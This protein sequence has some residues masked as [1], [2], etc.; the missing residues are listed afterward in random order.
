MPQRWCRWRCRVPDTHWA[1]H[2]GGAAS[3]GCAGGAR[4]LTGR[5][6]QFE[7]ALSHA[8]VGREGN[9]DASGR[10]NVVARQRGARE[11]C[12]LDAAVRRDALHSE[13]VV[14]SLQREADEAQTDITAGSGS[15][16]AGGAHRVLCI[17]SAPDRHGVGGTDRPHAVGRVGVRGTLDVGHNGATAAPDDTGGLQWETRSRARQ[18]WGDGGRGRWRP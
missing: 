14:V 1:L 5:E 15:G 13:K 18:G 12:G 3:E 11:V 9:G 7:T 4:A 2:R 10:D 17:A 16:R 8:V 6:S